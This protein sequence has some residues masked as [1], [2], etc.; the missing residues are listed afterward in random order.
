[1]R[2]KKAKS[3]LPETNQARASEEAKSIRNAYS[4]KGNALKPLPAEQINSSSLVE[5]KFRSAKEIEEL[6][7]KNGKALFGEQ[8]IIV[9]LRMKNSV[10][11]SGSATDIFLFDIKDIAKPKF[12]VVAA[13]L[14]NGN[15]YQSIFPKVTWC[16]ALFKNEEVVKC[17]ATNWLSQRK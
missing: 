3:I 1:M 13:E 4:L 8:T 5:R 7:L 17:Y 15:F 2:A 10:F 14:A 9:P 16:F 12:Y 6:I 11:K